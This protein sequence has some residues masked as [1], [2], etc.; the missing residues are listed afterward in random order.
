MGRNIPLPLPIIVV[1]NNK[2]KTSEIVSHNRNEVLNWLTDAAAA[3]AAATGP[4]NPDIISDSAE[5]HQVRYE[6]MLRAINWL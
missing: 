3:A 6:V 1:K 4:E 5:D 2:K